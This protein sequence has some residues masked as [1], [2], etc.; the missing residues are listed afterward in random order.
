[1]DKDRAMIHTIRELAM[2]SGLLDPLR[3]SIGVA[4][5]LVCPHF[6]LSSGASSCWP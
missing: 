6:T 4:Q 1:M 5:L 3:R 2:S